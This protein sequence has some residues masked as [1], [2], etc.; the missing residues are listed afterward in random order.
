MF[1]TFAILAATTYLVLAGLHAYWAC[2]GLWPGTDRDSL[3]RLVVGG[4]QGMRGPGPIATWVVVAVLVG[5]AS[6][7]LGGA[8][9][10]ESP[11]PRAW[12]RSAALAGAVVLLLRGLGGFFDTALRPAT[13]G[14]PFAR[15]NVRLYS[16]L[17]LI[18]ALCTVTAV[19]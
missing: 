8:G 4:P 17:C 1:M 11:I 16:P 12:L 14:S 9:V 13:R 15:L 3:N 10:V 7:V 19:L 18:L 6:T 2:G 5:A